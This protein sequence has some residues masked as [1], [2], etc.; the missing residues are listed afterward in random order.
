MNPSNTAKLATLGNTFTAEFSNINI[1]GKFVDFH[2]YSSACNAFVRVYNKNTLLKSL[3]GEITLNI[4]V[5]FVNAHTSCRVYVR[6]MRVLKYVDVLRETANELTNFRGPNSY[7][8]YYANQDIDD[9]LLSTPAGCMDHL[10]QIH[11]EDHNKRTRHMTRLSCMGCKTVVYIPEYEKAKWTNN[12]TH[13][14]STAFHQ[15]NWFRQS[16]VAVADK[17]Y[18]PLDNNVYVSTM[19]FTSLSEHLLGTKESI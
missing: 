11:Q 19:N 15:Q 17:K 9:D 3:T 13:T 4:R 1:H 5:D 10:L 7:T 18:I 14:T 8:G 6:Q 2:C 12:K 16:P